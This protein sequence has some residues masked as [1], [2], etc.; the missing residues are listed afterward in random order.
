MLFSDSHIPVDLVMMQLAIDKD[1]RC[2]SRVR[3]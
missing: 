1:R 2:R 3:A